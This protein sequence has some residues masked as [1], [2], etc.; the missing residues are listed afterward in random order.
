MHYLTNESIQ[1]ILRDE[2]VDARRRESNPSVE[3]SRRRRRAARTVEGDDARGPIASVY[4]ART[5]PT[6][7]SATPARETCVAGAHTRDG[8]MSSIVGD[9]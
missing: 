2:S 6:R 1:K 8:R 7:A 9:A 5:A 3:S 4:I